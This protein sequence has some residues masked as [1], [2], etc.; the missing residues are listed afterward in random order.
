MLV[1]LQGCPRL[2]KLEISKWSEPRAISIGA[3]LKVVPLPHLA[4]MHA[5]LVESTA[6]IML[7]R[8]VL[9]PETA[10]VYYKQHVSPYFRTFGDLQF[11]PSLDELTP[12]IPY[13]RTVACMIQSDDRDSRLSLLSYLRDCRKPSFVIDLPG[14]DV[15]SSRLG[16]WHFYPLHQLERLTV[17]DAT[18][19]AEHAEPSTDWWTGTLARMTALETLRI[20]RPEND[21]I[22]SLLLEALAGDEDGDGPGPCP[23]LHT[24]TLDNVV[25]SPE[26]RA[27]LFPIFH[28]M[29]ARGVPLTGL[30]LHGITGEVVNLR[31]GFVAEQAGAPV[32]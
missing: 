19:H 5:N 15:R 9:L 25:D 28:A 17:V 27:F 30:S 14:Y 31:V 21:G 2:E 22:F 23:A 8:H 18:T 20:A 6:F 4:S 24:L 13:L 29:R 16:L 10:F 1:V 11:I 26:L 32:S 7:L 3:D 12:P